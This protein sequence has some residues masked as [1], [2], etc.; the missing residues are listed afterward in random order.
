MVRCHEQ[1]AS[2]LGGDAV[3]RIEQS[4]QG[5]M[6]GVAHIHFIIGTHVLLIRNKGGIDVFDQHY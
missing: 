2:V 4:R 5:H 3:D 1:D 6:L